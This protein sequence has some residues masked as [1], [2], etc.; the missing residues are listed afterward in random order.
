M[1]TFTTKQNRGLNDW[2]HLLAL[3][4]SVGGS[5][6]LVSIQP[7]WWIEAVR[8]L[9]RSWLIEFGLESPWAAVYSIAIVLENPILIQSHLSVLLLVFLLR[10]FHTRNWLVLNKKCWPILV[11][12]GTNVLIFLVLANTHQFAAVSQKLYPTGKYYS[13]Y[14]LPFCWEAEFPNGRALICRVASIVAFTV[15]NLVALQLLISRQFLAW[16]ASC[17][18]LSILFLMIPLVVAVVGRLIS[19]N[20][21]ILLLLA[22]VYSLLAAGGLWC[23]SRLRTTEQKDHAI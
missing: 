11:A 16:L 9:I 22:F 14:R 18:L 13:W 20:C 5:C 4:L 7:I 1:S 8:K 23:C 10:T 12:A 6:L 3:F 2:I 17:L 15:V 19:I 21:G